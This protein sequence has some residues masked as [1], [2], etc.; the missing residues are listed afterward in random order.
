VRRAAVLAALFLLGFLASA[1][2]LGRSA[3]PQLITT[4][5]PTI[6][7]TLP[8]STTLPK[9]TTTL[10]VTTTIPKITTTI[11]KVTT[12]VPKVTTTVPTL[13]VSTSV[14]K[15]TTTL[16]KVTTASAATGTTGLPKASTSAVPLG[17]NNTAGA[18]PSSGSSVGGAMLSGSPSSGSGAAQP[19]A[20]SAA[21][22]T[23]STASPA[24]GSAPLTRLG[25]VRPFLSL[26][27][28]RA[29]RVAILVFRLR[30]AARVRFTV[31]QVF[32]LCRVVG[33]FSV[34]GHAGI[35]RFRFNGRVRG[36]RL[37]PGTYQIGL[38][39]K[40]GRLLR[41]AIAILDA[42]VASRS[43]VATARKRNVCGSTGALA[44]FPGSTLLPPIDAQPAPEELN[45]SGSTSSHHV[46]GVDVTAPRNLV[47]EIDKNPLAIVALGLAVFLLAMA[48]VP[49][50]AMPGSR[51]ADLLARER[52]AL[53]FAGAVALTVGGIILALA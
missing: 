26:H 23:A 20:A 47:K 45:P 33:S 11:P 32:P 19:G 29:H 10:P 21:L 42:P 51:A 1:P 24:A 13:P 31:V 48:A 7:T 28:S 27:G 53:V 2:I 49:Q 40:R 5:L 12:T 9:V 15:V 38:R 52:T 30:H 34:R 25:T 4:A 39:S 14:P 35:N 18:V 50:A 43:A 16:P 41:V 6:S 17:G 22:F 46:L 36:T 37:D 44:S 8:V 3:V